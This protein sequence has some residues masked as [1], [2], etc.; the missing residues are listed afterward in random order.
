MN[1]LNI[2]IWMILSM[3]FIV[4]CDSD[5]DSN[6]TLQSPDSFMLNVPPDASS[7]VYDLKNTETVELTCLQPDYGF[8]AATTYS[9]QVSTNGQFNEAS[10]DTP[11]SY[12]TLPTPYTTAKMEV[13]AIEMAVA[14]V[15]LLGV[16]E[17]KDFPKDP[18]PVHIR[19]KAALHNNLNQVYSNAIEL[20]KVLGYFALDAMTMPNDMY[21]IGSVNEWKW[22]NSYPMVPIHS[23]DGK[24]WSIQYFPAGAEI[25]FNTTK[26]W[27]GGEFGFSENRVPENS[28]TYAGIEDA[29]GNIKINNEGWYIVWVTTLIEGRSYNY[30]VEF[31]TPKVYLIGETAGGWDI[32]DSNLFTVPADGDGEFVSPAFIADNELR[33]CI[34]L[35][36]VEWWQTEFIIL[37]GKIEY[38]GKGDDQ[39]RV[40]VTS[41]QKAYL[42]FPKGTGVIND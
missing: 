34:K 6:P 29:G 3:L 24:F 2:A 30:T 21:I 17:E 31:L 10:G 42:N 38:R 8:T 5:R 33:M 23:N 16:T 11:A 28:A 12:V 39:E 35:D 37:N 41:G 36:G 13:D 32:K 9:V 19:L 22:E 15:G 4:S 25:K 14:I 18:F 26:S 27:D 7:A 40:S 20:P 1:K